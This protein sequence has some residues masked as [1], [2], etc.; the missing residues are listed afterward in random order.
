MVSKGNP[1]I[2][3][4]DV[5]GHISQEGILS[6]YFGV[7]EIPAC[8][9]NP[10]RKDRHPSLYFYRCRNNRI[11]VKD[12]ATGEWGSLFGFMSRMW[13]I[14]ITQV[15]SKLMNDEYCDTKPER[16]EKQIPS[17]VELQCK[18]RDWKVYDIAYWES[19]GITRQW[20]EYADIHPI[21]HKIMTKNG[22]RYIFG[23]DKYAYAFIEH[24]E[25]KTTMKIYQPFNKRG[26]K[27]Q[28]SHDGSVI[29]LWTKIPK[30][31][32]VVCICS[33]VKDALC[34]WCNCGIPSVAMQGEGYQIS[35]TALKV[36]KKR[37]KRVCVLFDIDKPGLELSEKF[38]ERTGFERIIMPNVNNAKDISDLYHEISDKNKFVQIITNLFKNNDYEK[39]HCD[40][41]QHE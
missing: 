14:T 23:A 9:C 39:N 28:N 40:C 5:L 24:K 41:K 33:S 11:Y 22:K 7:T 17:H 21:S 10:I 30:F 27:W 31:G 29:S 18:T 13:N 2:T 37:F 20:L 12:F 36:L 25:G 34:L 32:K 6:K 15:F 26:F 1:T 16:R 19:Y 35:N 8:I 3:E 38:C 4:D